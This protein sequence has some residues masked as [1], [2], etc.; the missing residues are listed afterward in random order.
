MAY[1]TPTSAGHVYCTINGGY[2]W[3]RL[4]TP[5]NQGLNSIFAYDSSH[6]YAAGKSSGVVYRIGSRMW[7]AVANPIT[8]GPPLFPPA[9]PTSLTAVAV[10]DTQINL[11][12]TD[13]STDEVGFKVER[14]PDGLAWSP[15]VTLGANANS[16]PNAGLLPSTTYY[17]RVYAYNAIGNSGYSNVAYATTMAIPPVPGDALLLE[18]GNYL[19][20]EDGFHMEIE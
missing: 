12:W 2:T 14:G 20:L 4:A 10:S 8:P 1:N 19:L 13:N 3:E 15:L 18:T 5:N 7:E 9:A 6:A 11:A 17:Y 16:Y